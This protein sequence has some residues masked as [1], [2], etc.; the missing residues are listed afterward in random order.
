MIEF[1][2]VSKKYKGFLA[3]DNISFKIQKGEV[4]GY[5][6]PN[7]AGK[8]TTIKILVSLIKD[9]SGDV[10]VNGKNVYNNWEE[11]HKLIGYHP[12]EAGFQE[13]RTIDH[14]LKTFGRLSGLTSENL[15]NRIQ[16]VLRLLN[17][18]DVR[19][20]KI[21]H[22]SGGMFQKL[23]LVQALLHEPEIL[24]LDE[25][26]TGLD[27]GTRIQFKKI[28]KGLAKSG[29]TI[30]F[31]SHILSDVQDIADKIGILNRGKIMKIGTPE[32][33]QN[34]F[35]VGNIL[36]IAV[37]ENTPLCTELENISGVDYF[38]KVKSYKQ[39]V[40]LK[41]EVDIDLTIHQIMAM[42]NEQKCKVRNFN[43]IKPSLE[44]VYLKYVGGESE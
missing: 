38:E 3:L 13:W 8:T 39:L 5:I 11:L 6:G 29:K 22:L 27:P 42:L 19:D 12:Q 7:G 28:I 10:Y 36:E 21:V 4:F 33:L 37:V 16:E 31:S 1:H 44:E 15:E 41:S 34:S 40:H 2:N 30:L 32:E 9:Y 24:V 14:S 20:K 35:H 26:L 25:P 43:L 18:N 17:L 23:R